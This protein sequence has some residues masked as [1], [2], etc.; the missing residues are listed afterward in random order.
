VL[1]SRSRTSP[2]SVAVVDASS[3]VPNKRIMLPALASPHTSHL[4]PHTSH[5][6]THNSQ[7]TSH[8]SHLTSHISHLTPHTSHLTPHTSH[9][10]SHTSHLTTH[11]S[12][13]TP[14]TSR[15][16]ASVFFTEMNRCSDA[17]IAPL[18]HSASG[19]AVRAVPTCACLGH[20]DG[21]EFGYVCAT[22]SVTANPGARDT[23]LFA[24]EESMWWCANELT[25]CS[26]VFIF[27][28][29]Q[30]WRLT[31]ENLTRI[32]QTKIRNIQ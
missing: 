23:R 17:D 30:R 20:F 4:T 29:F 3:R 26:A 24:K 19:C 11:N 14:L 25:I 12:Q 10:T 15:I 13:L 22:L 1:H 28:V 21:S 18:P 2:S 7:L 9:L 32:I 6:T 16:L 31:A 5:L 27:S 8:N